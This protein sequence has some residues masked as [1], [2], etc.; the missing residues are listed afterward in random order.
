MG[1]HLT[2]VKM[3]IINKSTNKGWTGCGEKGTLLHC[4]WE[5]KLVQPLWRYLGK[6]N[7][8]LLYDPSILRLHIYLD[9][10]FN[11]NDTC[12]CIFTETL[13]TIAKT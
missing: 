3:A 11:E 7:I 1:Y 5:C 10:T 2:P 8:E 13:S 12:T 6:L 4:W 9:K